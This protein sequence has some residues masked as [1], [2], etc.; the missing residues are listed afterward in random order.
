MIHPPLR[1]PGRGQREQIY[2]HPLVDVE[3]LLHR[4]GAVT[5]VQGQGVQ[6]F[7]LAD[8]VGGVVGDVPGLHNVQEVTSDQ[9]RYILE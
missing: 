7:A 1:V 5:L 3:V 9:Y 2:C 6:G 8:E 4:G